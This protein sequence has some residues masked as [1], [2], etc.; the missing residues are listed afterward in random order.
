M[1]CVGLLGRGGRSTEGWAKDFL[2]VQWLRLCASTTGGAGSIRGQGTKALHV[3]WFYQ[4]KK[5]RMIHR[6]EEH[7]CHDSPQ[8]HPKVRIG[9]F[10]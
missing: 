6:K 8:V 2:V 4:K 10:W 3:K 1:A 5:R 7:V 9:W